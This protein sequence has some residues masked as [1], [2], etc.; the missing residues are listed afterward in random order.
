M[1]TMKYVGTPTAV[2]GMQAPFGNSHRLNAAGGHADYCDQ[3]A[4]QGVC[5]YLFGVP[6]EN[7]KGVP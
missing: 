7:Q 1:Q 5:D 2:S 3:A 4:Y 6:P